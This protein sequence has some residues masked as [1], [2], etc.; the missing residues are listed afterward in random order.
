MYDLVNI[1]RAF[2][3]LCGV[4][5]I[6]PTSNSLIKNQELMEIV[7]TSRET[8][9]V[10]K[11]PT[12]QLRSKVWVEDANGEVVFG[13]GRYRMLDAVKRLGSLQAAAKELKMSYR[14]IWARVSATEKRLGKEYLEYKKR[15]PMFVPWLKL[16]TEHNGS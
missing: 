7:D 2:Q 14:A 8:A 13:L 10:T 3:K 11:K 9:M 1:L 16:K 15:T 4:L 6:S 5:I 12:F